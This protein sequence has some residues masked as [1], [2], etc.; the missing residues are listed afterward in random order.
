MQ[1]NNLN[2]LIGKATM[3]ELQGDVKTARVLFSQAENIAPKHMKA[4]V[5]TLAAM[6]LRLL[7]NP[8]THP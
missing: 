2:A 7:D 1:K 6:T 3:R 5:H 4:K 8:S